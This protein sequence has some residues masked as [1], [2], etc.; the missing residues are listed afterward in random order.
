MRR[1]SCWAISCRLTGSFVCINRCRSDL[2]CSISF[3]RPSV[4]PSCSSRVHFSSFSL[5]APPKLWADIDCWNKSFSFS[6]LICCHMPPSFFCSPARSLELCCFCPR[7]I[8]LKEVF[9]SSSAFLTCSDSSPSLLS[10]FSCA[11]RT[12]VA[13]R[14]CS[15]SRFSSSTWAA[16]ATLPKG[17]SCG[18]QRIPAKSTSSTIAASTKGRSKRNGTTSLGVIFSARS[19]A[20][21]ATRGLYSPTA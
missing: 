14:L 8:C 12:S 4:E 6:A 9:S 18:S 11:V 5:L 2:I 16:S 17:S 7:F 20:S 19:S 13:L 3:F 21:W 1:L 10:F 15:N